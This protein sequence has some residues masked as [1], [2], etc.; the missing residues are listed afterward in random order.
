MPAEACLVL[1]FRQSGRCGYYFV[2]HSARCLFW[3]EEFDAMALLDQVRVEFTPPLVG[4]EMKSLYWCVPLAA[5]LA[6]CYLI[7]EFRLH[8]EYFPE[9]RP[10]KVDA[11]KELKDVLIHAIG[12]LGS[13]LHVNI[14][15]VLNIMMPD[16]LTSPWTMSPYNLDHL[17]KM[18]SLV[19]DIEC[20]N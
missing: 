10:F 3:L 11:L 5:Y 20:M 7:Y 9:L 14:Y 4:Q 6:I 15:L 12:G 19:K 18:L 2:D 17:Q 13:T 16:S 1:E 8:N